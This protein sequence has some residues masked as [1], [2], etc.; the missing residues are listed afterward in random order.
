MSNNND[1][2]NQQCTISLFPEYAKPFKEFYLTTCRSLL[3]AKDELLSKIP[4]E[5]TERTGPIRTPVEGNPID[6]KPIAVTSKFKISTEA[7]VNCDV[8]QFLFST[9]EA[10]DSERASLM[11]QFFQFVSDICEAS[12]Q[13]VDA[14]GQ[15]FSWDFIIDLID[16]V[17]MTFDENGRLLQ[18]I[19]V[20]PDMLKIIEAN[21]PTIE[22][23]QLL[24]QLIDR[25]R[26]EFLAKKR[27]RR[28]Y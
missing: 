21:P 16:K 4:I 11:P 2:E 10:V 28:I 18:T 9:D 6:F 17:E 19:V 25:K 3:A 24:D 26:D 23:Q 8:E 5:T 13:V 14:Q 12:G 20:S 1:D 7:I 27:S 15:P 22:Q